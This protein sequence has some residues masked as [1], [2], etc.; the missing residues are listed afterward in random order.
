MKASRLWIE[1]VTLCAGV[2]FGLALAL[3]TLG[4]V[5]LA[6]VETDSAQAA[7]SPAQNTFEGMVTCSRCGAK[8]SAKIGRTASD[9]ARVCVHGGA[10]FALVAGDK[11]YL[12]DGDMVALKRLA[13]QR[14]RIIGALNGST[15]QV[16][17]VAAAT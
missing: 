8:H 6:F 10:G 14:A 17:S 12:L 3:A 13:G 1:L 7:E 9:C 4:A 5:T 2:A 16:A 11:L 15:I